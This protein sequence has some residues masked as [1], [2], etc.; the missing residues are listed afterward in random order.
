MLGTAYQQEIKTKEKLKTISTQNNC[1]HI[2]SFLILLHKYTA[3]FIYTHMYI[4][5]N[6]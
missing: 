6:F 5:S 1:Y 2:G 4:Y 3:L